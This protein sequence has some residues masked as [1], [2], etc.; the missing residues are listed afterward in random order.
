MKNQ[1]R[2]V[3]ME[4]HFPRQAWIE[5]PCNHVSLVGGKR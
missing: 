2:R 1:Q 3:R 5:Q 4:N